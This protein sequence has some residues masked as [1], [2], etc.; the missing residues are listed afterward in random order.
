MSAP[1]EQK[2]PEQENSQAVHTG[3]AEDWWCE[4]ERKLWTMLHVQQNFVQVWY[5]K[6]FRVLG[7]YGDSIR[8]LPPLKHVVARNM[9]ANFTTRENLVYFSWGKLL[10]VRQIKLL[11]EENV[12]LRKFVV[13]G[14]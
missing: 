7:T 14:V 6:N 1:T 10:C 8:H 9:P 12:S 13:W 11:S 2:V 5:H 3:S 4:D